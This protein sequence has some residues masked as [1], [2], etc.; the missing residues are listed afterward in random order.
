MRNKQIAQRLGLGVSTISTIWQRIFIKLGASNRANAVAIS[1][2]LLEKSEEP[3]SISTRDEAIE[4]FGASAFIRDAVLAIIGPDMRFE[5]L[6]DSIE[7]FLGV[8]A[9]KIIGKSIREVA[10]QSIVRAD[11]E[12]RVHDVFE[13]GSPQ[14]ATYRL[15]LMGRETYMHTV[16]RPERVGGTVARCFVT[17]IDLGVVRSVAMEN[18][19]LRAQMGALLAVASDPVAILCGAGRVMDAN[20]RFVDFVLETTGLRPEV[21]SELPAVD[22]EP[23]WTTVLDLCRTESA[24][25]TIIELSGSKIRRSVVAVPAEWLG[26][27]YGKCLSISPFAEQPTPSDFAT[28]S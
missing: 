5:F 27:V 8:S 4:E 15:S 22:R 28:V 17:F 2:Q 21:G 14:S 13:T 11:F 9:S 19:R 1:L 6:D 12:Q 26:E 20:A 24:F 3:V 25:S 7:T 16:M 23:T 10:S 18:R